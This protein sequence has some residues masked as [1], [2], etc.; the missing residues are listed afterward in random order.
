MSHTQT[1]AWRRTT[2]LPAV[3]PIPPRAEAPEG[4]QPRRLVGERS[5]D[6]SFGRGRPA[7]GEFFVLPFFFPFFFCILS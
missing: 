4:P 2:E 7:H 1:G 3:P 6:R 5:P